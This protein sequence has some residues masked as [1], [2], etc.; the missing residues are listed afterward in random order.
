VRFIRLV[1]VAC[2]ALGVLTA[3]GSSHR[4]TSSHSGQV[5]TGSDTVTQARAR[6]GR[7]IPPPHPGAT[8]VLGE[9]G[10]SLL[11]PVKRAYS[12]VPGVELTARTRS[13]SDGSQ[14]RRFLLAMQNGTVSAEE[15]IGPGRHGLTLVARENSPTFMRSA[16]AT[17]WRPLHHSTKRWILKRL[18]TRTGSLGRLEK[19]DPR[20]LLN[21]GYWFPDEGKALTLGHKAGARELLIET[22]DAFWFL[23]GTAKLPHPVPKSFLTITPQREEPPPSAL[24]PER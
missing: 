22:H 14:P 23:A 9:Q 19:S 5:S 1:A 8:V 12:H 7:R 2:L 11:A 6:S 16:G 3:C 18:K 13:I 10:E 4:L 20:T 17:C 24:G 15:F 21:V